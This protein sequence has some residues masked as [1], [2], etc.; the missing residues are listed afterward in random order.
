VDELISY[1]QK[2]MLD[3]YIQSN[4]LFDILLKEHYKVITLSHLF[5]NGIL[6]QLNRRSRSYYYWE[7]TKGSIYYPFIS[8]SLD[9][10]SNLKDSKLKSQMDSYSYNVNLPSVVDSVVNNTIGPKFVYAHFMVTHP[11]Y[12]FN[13]DG[14]FNYHENDQALVPE[15]IDQVKILN[16]QLT[17]IIDSILKRNASNSVIIVQADHGSHL[18]NVNETFTIQN[19]YYFPDLDYSL[20]HQNISP[21]NSFRVVLNKYFGQQLPLLEDKSI[22]ANY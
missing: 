7:I 14:T 2:K 18:L 9:M 4:L 5:N 1:S 20:L 3:N 6:Q 8:K 19:N 21:V 22:G 15:Y 10:L 12:V 11:P 13:A 16:R 17:T